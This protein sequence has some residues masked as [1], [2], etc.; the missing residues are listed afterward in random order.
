MTYAGKIDIISRWDGR[1]V[2]MRVIGTH[3]D[4]AKSFRFTLH[5]DEFTV[6]YFEAVFTPGIETVP[7]WGYFKHDVVDITPMINDLAAYKQTA[8]LIRKRPY[9]MLLDNLKL[10]T[11]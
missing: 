3:N 11:R 4:Q 7:A 2:D 6:G 5:I 10:A 1:R 9:G 8:A